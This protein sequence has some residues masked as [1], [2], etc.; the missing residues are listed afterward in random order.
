MTLLVCFLKTVLLAHKKKDTQKNVDINSFRNINE[1]DVSDHRPFIR[2]R[3]VKMQFVQNKSRHSK[4]KR[5][6]NIALRH[7]C[8][9]WYTS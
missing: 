6:K 5:P 2:L 3:K 7:S 1:H 4:Q 9:Y 8:L